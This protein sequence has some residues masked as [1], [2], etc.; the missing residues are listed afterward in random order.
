MWRKK[1]V[2]KDKNSDL[3]CDDKKEKK[4]KIFLM[5]KIFLRREF[6]SQYEFMQS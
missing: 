4:K 3:C 1:V 5:K 6:H 2:F